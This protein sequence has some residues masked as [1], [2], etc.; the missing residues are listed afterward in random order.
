MIATATPLEISGLT[1]WLRFFRYA[2]K[3]GG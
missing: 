1:G 3:F 2:E